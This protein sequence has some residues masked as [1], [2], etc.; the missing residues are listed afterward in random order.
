[1]N[2]KLIVGLVVGAVLVFIL[3]ILIIIFVYAANNKIKIVK[4]SPGPDEMLNL[5]EVKIYNEKYENIAATAD[6]V[7]S[8][9]YN[10]SDAT[11]AQNIVDGDVSTIAHTK[12]IAEDPTPFIQFTFPKEVKISKIVIINREGFESRIDGGKIE[13]FS[14]KN[15]LVKT[16]PI[17]GTANTYEFENK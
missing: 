13:L 14:G 5:A 1:M 4:I 2:K 6:I 3:S 12:P 11:Q 7:L 16:F 10:D 17:V 15:K 9:T 8:T